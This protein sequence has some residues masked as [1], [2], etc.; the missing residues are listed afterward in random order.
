MVV[1]DD[2]VAASVG[3]AEQVLELE[4]HDSGGGGG[5]GVGSMV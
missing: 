4:V 3:G 5:G 1:S 2:G